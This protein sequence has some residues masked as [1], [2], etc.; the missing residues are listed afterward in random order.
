MRR[1]LLLLTLVVACA[2]TTETREARVRGALD[3]VALAVDP[4]SQ[5]A[6]D[7]CIAQQRERATLA[8]AGQEKVEDA[9][10][11]IAAI[12]VRCNALRDVFEA[13]RGAH[14]EA[15]KLVEAGAI[16][17]AEAKLEEMR[18]RWRALFVEAGGNPP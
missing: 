3:A 12:R 13:L 4:A 5:L 17:Q 10:R 15:R 7:L 11:E 1:L 2:S 9:E 14:D 6:A 18:A 16:E 8:E